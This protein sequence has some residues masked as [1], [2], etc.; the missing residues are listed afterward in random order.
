MRDEEVRGV[1]KQGYWEKVS[2]EIEGGG[3]ESGGEVR[4]VRGV[5]SISC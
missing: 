5:P 4:V 3:G 2:E 1:R